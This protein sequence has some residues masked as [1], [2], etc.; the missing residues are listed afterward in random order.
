MRIKDIKKNIKGIFKLPIKKYYIGKILH[1]NPYFTPWNFNS[2]IL[3]IRK[4]KPKY[5]R[6]NH[7]KLFRYDISYGWPI[8]ISSYNLGWKDKF[9]T[10]R[11]EW[12]A[13]FQIYFFKWQFCVYWVSPFKD[14]DTY[15]EMILWF[16]I[17]S[18]CDLD[19]A[20]KTWDWVDYKTKKSTWNDE[21]LINNK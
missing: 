11:F 5:L 1:G 20:K 6:C 12:N 21:Y 18:D 16:I 3:T 19:K 7:F 17:Y 8:I 9:G 2:S 10:P 15:W 4:K 13:A 14:E